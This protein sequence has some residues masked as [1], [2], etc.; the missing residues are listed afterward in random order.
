MHPEASTDDKRWL[1]ARFV[2]LS[3]RLKSQGAPGV[4]I[5]VASEFS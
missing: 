5:V 2:E 4:T 1:A 3:R